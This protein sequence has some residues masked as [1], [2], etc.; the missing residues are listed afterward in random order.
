[1]QRLEAL[2]RRGELGDP[3]C[4]GDPI[5]S[6]E[7]VHGCAEDVERREGDVEERRPRG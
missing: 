3:P 1:V 2:E 6:D 5:V 4:A 7:P